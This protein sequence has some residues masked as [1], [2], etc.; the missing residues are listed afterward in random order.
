MIRTLRVQNFLSLK[1]FSLDFTQLNVLVGPNMSGKTNI[2]NALRFLTSFLSSNL[3]QALNEQGTIS[4]VFWKGENNSDISLSFDIDCT[5][6]RQPVTF[7]YSIELQGSKAGAFTIEKEHLEVKREGKAITLIKTQ[8]GQ[9]SVLHVDGKQAFPAPDPTH[10]ALEY[11]VPGW[12]G[13]EI[14][15]LVS[16]MHFYNLNPAA[17]KRHN[18]IKSEAFLNTDGSNISSWLLNFQTRHQKEFRELKQAVTDALPDIE[19]ILTVPT[20]SSMAF[21]ATK[22]KFLSSPVPMWRMSDGEL[23]FLAYVSL[24]FA[25]EELGAPVVCIEEPENYMNPRLLEMLLEIYNQRRKALGE[26]AAQVIIT[27]HSPSLVNK[28]ELDELVITRK[29]G[30]RTTCVRASKIG[31]NFKKLIKE[32]EIGLGELWQSGALNAD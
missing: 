1:E 18:P 20:Q 2:I 8:R 3:A 30:G 6:P 31:S 25:P 29:H 22:E 27:T 26:R 32:E 10:S 24:V 9:G 12:Y 7:N 13:T 16:R 15:Y 14:K 5:I 4:E 21:L 17:M 23:V 11:A 28:I 19:E